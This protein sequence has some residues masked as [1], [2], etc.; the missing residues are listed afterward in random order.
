MIPSRMNHENTLFAFI[1]ARVNRFVFP[2]IILSYVLT[3]LSSCSRSFLQFMPPIITMIQPSLDNIW[4]FFLII[5]IN[6]NM[7]IFLFKDSI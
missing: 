5:H 4:L 1:I 2:L 6:L 7:L 3:I